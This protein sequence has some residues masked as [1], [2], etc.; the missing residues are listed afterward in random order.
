VRKNTR[1]LLNNT[2]KALFDGFF[3]QAR[4]F[5]HRA[6]RPCCKESNEAWMK[7]TQKEEGG[8]FE[9]AAN[10]P[11]PCAFLQLHTSARPVTPQ[12]VR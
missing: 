8:V 4:R 2:C 1:S 9:M 11:S 3:I 7:E 12:N 10:R 5:L 6:P